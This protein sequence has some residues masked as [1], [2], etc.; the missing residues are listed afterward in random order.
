MGLIPGVAMLLGA[1]I[2]FLYPLHGKYLEEVQSKVLQ[3]HAEKHQ[4]LEKLS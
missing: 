2:L 3:M 4:E 1:L